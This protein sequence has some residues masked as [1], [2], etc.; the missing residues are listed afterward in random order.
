MNTTLQVYPNPAKG[1][2]RVKTGT[3]I[4]KVL[5]ISVYDISGKNI[6]NR[7]CTGEEIYSFDLTGQPGGF[8]FVR[9]Q[10]GESTYTRRIMLVD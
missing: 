2:F 6:Q 10:A 3:D 4:D 7:V 5:G 8:Y 1:V 9:I